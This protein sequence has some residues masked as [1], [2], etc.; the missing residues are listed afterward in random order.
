MERKYERFGV[1]LDVSRNAVLKVSEAKRMID[2]LQKMGYNTVELYSEDT[3]E[4]EG[5]PYF[6]YMRGRYT[7]AELKEIDAYAVSK[8][9]ELIPCIQTLAHFTNLVRHAVYHPI[10]DCADILLIDEP[11]T[12]EFIEKMF[13]FTKIYDIILL[14]QGL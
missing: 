6:G 8:G 4:I 2:Y 9:V 14:Q 11:K 13:T 3:Y 5:E 10:V 7:A 1:M 12:Y